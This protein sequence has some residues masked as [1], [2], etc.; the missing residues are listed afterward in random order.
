MIFLSLLAK[1]FA[2]ALV[3]LHPWLA[4]ALWLGGVAADVRVARKWSAGWKNV[5]FLQLAALALGWVAVGACDYAAMRWK[6]GIP[7]FATLLDWMLSLTGLEVGSQSGHV[8]L[9]TMAGPLD[10]AATL[11]G[12]ALKV[13]VLFFAMAAVWLLWAETSLAEVARKLGIVAG[14]LIAVALLRMACIV[15]L[16]NGLFDFVGYESEEL[17]W[18]PFMDEAANVWAYLPFLL[19]AGALL[20]RQLSPPVLAREKPPALPP[21]LI[22][23]GLAVLLLL[24]LAT[25]WQPAGTAKSGRLVIAGYHSQW[26]R[27]DRPYDRDWYGADSGYNYAVMKRLFEK[28]YQVSDATGPITAADLDGASVL[29]VYD[30]DRRFSQEEIGRIREFVRGGG[31]LMVIG[32]HTNVFGSTSHLN[33]LCEPFGFQYRDDV[34]FDLD[35]DFHQILDAPAAP[36]G[37][38]HGMAFFKLRGPTSIRPTSL[39]TRCIYDVG[40]SKSVRAIYSVNNFYPPPHDDPKMRFGDFCVAAASRYGSGRVV[41]WADST[42]FS[43]FEIFYPG[44]Y[45]FLLNSTQWLNHRDGVQSQIGRRM[46]PLALALGL[47]AFL[48]L[49]RDP[50][51]WLATL[52][53][54]AVVLGAARFA[55]GWFERRR[56]E[57]PKPIQPS[58]WV[59]FAADPKDQAHH[60]RDFMGEGPYDQ[61]Y[62]VFIQWVLRTGA[63]A[64]FHILGDDKAN[65]LYRE[66]RETNTATTARALIVRTPDDLKQLRELAEIPARANDPLLLM[67]SATIPPETATEEIRKAGL[68]QNAETLAKVASAWPSGEIALDDGGR[69]IVVAANAERFSDQAMG[70]SEKVTPDAAQRTLFDQ[71]FGVID[72]LFGHAPPA[73]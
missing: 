26:S 63:F 15:L 49:R 35:A 43:N 55:G 42:V 8:Y 30:P 39:W 18:R 5:V 44:K 40:H 69:K 72:Q 23:G 71:A 27:S 19:A 34:L 48:L 22:W 36:S 6:D 21:M 24:G 50:R 64:C 29:V 11:D 62:E 60:L 20:G 16:A 66:L 33:E 7:V 1:T 68:I 14:V 31:G 4:A 70:I 47:A 61:R 17:P 65:G 57:F 37:F 28:F 53:A 59:V 3:F 25:Y 73:N 32:D 46:A 54:A 13:P 52:V 51:V 12:L 45:E 38:W 56:A 10:F 41:A 58:E 67:F 9:T 2:L